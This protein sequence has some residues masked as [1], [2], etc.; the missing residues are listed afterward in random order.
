MIARFELKPTDPA[1]VGSMDTPA[2]RSTVADSISE[3]TGC[4]AAVF[5]TAAGS[6]S[7]S[8]TAQEGSSCRDA[9]TVSLAHVASSGNVMATVRL[10]VAD[11][12]TASRQVEMLEASSAQR[13]L[14]LAIRDTAFLVQRRVEVAFE[15]S[16]E[17]GGD[18]ESRA[19]LISPQNAGAVVAAALLLLIALRSR[20][21][22]C[23][24]SVG[25]SSGSGEAKPSITGGGDNSAA[26]G[27]GSVDGSSGS[28][29]RIEP[30]PPRER[31]RTGRG[32]KGKRLLPVVDPDDLLAARTSRGRRKGE[33]EEDEEAGEEEGEGEGEGEGEEEV[34][35]DEG[36]EIIRRMKMK[37][38]ASEAE[39]RREAMKKGKADLQ[40]LHE[41][42][43]KAVAYDFD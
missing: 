25:G 29:E 17:V 41:R 35:R 16:D 31:K 33:E 42:S 3:L 18:A 38:K 23:R 4:T 40:Q 22:S 11:E 20:A 9:I 30:L 32:T 28:S 27:N 37:M 5:A 13:A 2:F 26:E 7:S 6:S 24:C 12:Q 1:E 14:A 8:S 15:S 21:A 43:S 19:E 34:E 36:A 10:Q 39:S